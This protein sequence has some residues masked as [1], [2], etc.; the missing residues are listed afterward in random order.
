VEWGTT[1]V[2]N[3]GWTMQV[4][5][6]GSFADWNCGREPPLTKTA[7]APYRRSPLSPPSSPL[8]L[9]GPRG[10]IFFTLLFKFRKYF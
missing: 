7:G 6:P 9:R 8:W 3:G 10:H 1:A 5:R 2:L 4:G